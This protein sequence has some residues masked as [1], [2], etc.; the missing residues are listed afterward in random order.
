MCA[1]VL[2][3]CFGV[4][5][6]GLEKKKFGLLEPDSHSFLFFFFLLFFNNTEPPFLFTSCR[7]S[8][9]PLARAGRG[10]ALALFN[11][12]CASAGVVAPPYYFGS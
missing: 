4:L 9:P 2:P 1:L 5:E 8:S 11:R 10:T 3:M 7:S 6:P 12:P